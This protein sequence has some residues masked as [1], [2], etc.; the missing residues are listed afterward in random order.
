MSVRQDVKNEDKKGFFARIGVG[1]KSCLIW[2]F[3]HLRQP[4]KVEGTLFCWL[5]KNI[6]QNIELTMCWSENIIF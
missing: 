1:Y 5:I 2:W 4:I 6:L 3:V